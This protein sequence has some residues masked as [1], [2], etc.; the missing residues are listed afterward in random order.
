MESFSRL[1]GR[2][3]AIDAGGGAITV[4]VPVDHEKVVP[5]AD[6]GRWC[7]SW[8]KVTAC[9]GFYDIGVML[10]LRTRPARRLVV[11]REEPWKGTPFQLESISNLE[12]SRVGRTEVRL[13]RTKVW[14]RDSAS[15]PSCEI[16]A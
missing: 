16:R 5:R 4:P 6:F 13:S 11:A 15:L 3:Y 7:D 9:G 10:Q 1:Q 12:G 8:P 2:P 14:L